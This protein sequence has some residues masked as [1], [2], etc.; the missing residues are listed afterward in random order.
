MLPTSYIEIS[1]SALTNNLTFIKKMLGPEVLFSSVVKGNAYGH[2][3]SAFCPLIYENGIRHFSVFSANEAAEVKQYLPSDITILIMGMI[4]HDQ[5]SWAIE[6]EIEFYIFDKDRLATALEYA[7][8]LNKAC[9]IH[10]EVETGMNR[11]GFALNELKSVW[12]I[13]LANH[14]H[15]DLKGVCTHLAGAES[16]ANYKRI[17]DQNKRLKK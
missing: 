17:K 5:I 1:K 12:Q 13:L 15:I 9:R 8:K 16:I 10:I 4:D 14:A 11:T 3:I 7:K 6:N 2:N